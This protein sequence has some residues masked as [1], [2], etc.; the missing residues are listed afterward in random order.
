MTFFHGISKLSMKHAR[1]RNSKMKSGTKEST[2]STIIPRLAYAIRINHFSRHDVR[3]RIAKNPFGATDG[4]LK[5]ISGEAAPCPCDSRVPRS[6]V[7]P[8]ESGYARGDDNNSGDDE[9]GNGEDGPRHQQ[10][11]IYVRCPNRIALHDHHPIGLMLLHSWVLEG[12]EKW[13]AGQ[14]LPSFPAGDE[15]VYSNELVDPNMIPDPASWGLYN[16]RKEVHVLG[17][18]LRARKGGLGGRIVRV[19]E[20][21]EILEH[22]VS[23]TQGLGRFAA[24]P[25][26]RLQDIKLAC[27]YV[28]LVERTEL[29]RIRFVLTI[30]NKMPAVGETVASHDGT[31]SISGARLDLGDLVP[32]EIFTSVMAR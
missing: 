3:I 16:D 29:I 15:L 21:L 19:T 23:T 5:F 4:A 28:A 8:S 17:Q 31:F 26:P 12:R 32:D 2:N 18:V 1:T 30:V 13:E 27:W 6:L 22:D 11:R 9:E 14:P 24:D 25:V 20:L 10:Q 7:V